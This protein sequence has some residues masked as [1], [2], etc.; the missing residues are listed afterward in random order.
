MLAQIPFMP[1][2]AAS[3]S[4]EVDLLFFYIS[5]VTGG[6]GILITL[7]LI[8]F[9]AKYARKREGEETPRILGSHRLEL[10]WTLTPTFI[11]LTFF[12]WGVVVYQKGLQPPADTPEIF[13]VGK[14][15][16]WKIQHPSGRREI[17]ELHLAVNQPVRITLISEDVIHSFGI[18]AFRDKVDVI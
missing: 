15:W 5:A 4:A 8:Y 10:M 17:N 12:A 3:I 13:V 18:P 11:F 9:C 2:Q 14:Q 6:V 7:A 16:M 1:D